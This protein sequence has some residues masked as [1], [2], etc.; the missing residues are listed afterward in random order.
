MQEV[1]VAVVV[2]VVVVVVVG[3]CLFWSLGLVWFGL[4]F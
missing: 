1:I 4:V 3:F 2:V